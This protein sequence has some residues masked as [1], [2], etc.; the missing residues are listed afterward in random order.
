MLKIVPQG[1]RGEVIEIETWIAASGRN[2]IRRD[3]VLR[4]L[5]SGVVFA[6]A[7]STLVAMNKQTRRVS[8]MPE[9]VRDELSTF[10]CEKQ[11]LKEN[12]KERIEKLNDKAKYV[13][14]DLKPM[15]SDL[16][17]NY[18]VNNVK[19]VKWIL[20]TVPEGFLK[21]HQISSMILEYKRECT[22]C[23]IV[24]SLCEPQE[25]EILGCINGAPFKY[26]HLLQIQGDTKN[27]D[28]VRARTLW[29]LKK[30][31]TVPFST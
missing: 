12:F 28:V 31:S 10:F 2:G 24:R 25:D 30:M 26:T 21:D 9:E 4:D 16:D 29:K 14:S 17:V 15:W 7:T 18:H 22:S 23:D 20:E 19:Y 3:W 11:V 1:H 27:A 5:A 8:K 13:T 6:V